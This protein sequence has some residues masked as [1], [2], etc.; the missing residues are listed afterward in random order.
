[1][2]SCQHKH[3]RR[4]GD[5][6]SSVCLWGISCQYGVFSWRSFLISFEVTKKLAYRQMF[7]CKNDEGQ[8]FWLA[9]HFIIYS[10]CL[11]RRSYTRV[12][13]IFLVSSRLLHELHV[14]DEVGTCAE[15][16]CAHGVGPYQH[17]HVLRSQVAAEAA[18]VVLVNIVSRIVG[19]G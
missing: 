13:I 3:N 14:A 9:P 7:L 10:A 17:E 18:L 11:R 15:R 1:M 16:A 4:Y 5:S 2:P 6:Q 12:S 8:A 19:R